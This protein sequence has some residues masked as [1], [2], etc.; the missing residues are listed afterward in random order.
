[1]LFHNII[2]AKITLAKGGS[3]EGDSPPPWDLENQ[4]FKYESST[5]KDFSDNIK[6][7]I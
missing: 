4:I 3:R 2:F 7:Y 5:R 6:K 1:M